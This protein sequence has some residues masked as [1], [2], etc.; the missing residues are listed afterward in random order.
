MKKRKSSAKR[1]TKETSIAIEMCIDGQGRYSISTQVP[2]LTHML[3]QI[4]KTQPH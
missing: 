1:K 4:F 3:E 2:F